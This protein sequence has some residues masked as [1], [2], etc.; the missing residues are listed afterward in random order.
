ML[1][2]FSSL[3]KSKYFLNLIFKLTELDEVVWN[4]EFLHLSDLLAIILL[5]QIA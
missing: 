4:F 3:K 2:M 5:S 1:I